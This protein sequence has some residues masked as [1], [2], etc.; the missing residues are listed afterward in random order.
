MPKPDLAQHVSSQQVV[1]I[2]QD[3]DRGDGRF[4]TEPGG[5][6]ALIPAATLS[7]VNAEDLP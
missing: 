3:T 5:L 2:L 7:Q 4:L 1:L 6:P